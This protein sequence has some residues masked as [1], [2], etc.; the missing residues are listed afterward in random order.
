M[1]TRITR[2]ASRPVQVTTTLPAGYRQQAFLDLSQSKAAIAGAVALGI[3]ILVGGS[4]LLVQ[5]VRLVRPAAL[6][7]L[8]LRN[9]VRASPGG[10]LFLELPLVEVVIAIL[11]MMVIRN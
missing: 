4:W 2:D 8:A 11:F 9:I 10:K 3:V 5:L 6:E 1:E 7:G